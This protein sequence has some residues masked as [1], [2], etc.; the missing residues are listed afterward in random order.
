MFVVMDRDDRGD[1][2]MIHRYSGS[3]ISS[4]TRTFGWVAFAHVGGG[5]RVGLRSVAFN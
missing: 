5:E 2:H 1:M 4:Y 3:K